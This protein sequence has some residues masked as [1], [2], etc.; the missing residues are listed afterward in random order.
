MQCDEFILLIHDECVCVCVPILQVYY[1]FIHMFSLFCS[2]TAGLFRVKNLFRG[3]QG[4]ID[5]TRADVSEYG[6]LCNAFTF[7]HILC[8]HTFIVYISPL[9]ILQN[10]VDA[11]VGFVVVVGSLVLSSPRLIRW[12]PKSGHMYVGPK[13]CLNFYR[14]CF[15]TL[16]RFLPNNHAI[17]WALYIY[18]LTNCVCMAWKK[19]ITGFEYKMEHEKKNRSFVRNWPVT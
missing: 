16:S 6:P 11:V 15:F 7:M 2:S 5:G 14:F 4:L 12:N 17:D 3:T 8:F 19:Q 9:F 13:H 18:N 10:K 1:H